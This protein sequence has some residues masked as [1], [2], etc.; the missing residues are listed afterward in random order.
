MVKIHA[1]VY[2][3]LLEDEENQINGIIHVIDSSG[4]GFQYMTIF[5][6]HEA[7]RIGKNLEVRFWFL[8]DFHG[9]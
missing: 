7:Y 9:I 8:L 2:E 6:P 5:T 4:L 1:I 3:T